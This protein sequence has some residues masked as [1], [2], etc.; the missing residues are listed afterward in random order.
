MGKYYYLNGTE[1]LG[2]FTID[3]LREKCITRETKVW[4]EELG[5]WTPAGNVPQLAQIFGA[6]SSPNTNDNNYRTDGHS[7]SQQP[8]KTWFVES[9]L[10]TVLCCLPFGI[11][12]MISAAKVESLFYSGDMQGAIDES[13]KAKKW[14]N[15]GVWVG[16]SAAVL[17]III[18]VIICVV[19][20]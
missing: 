13:N 12:G 16:V 17:Y 14:V 20:S 11:L 18:I 5:E 2:P 4:T 7:F 6:N 3:E 15:T 8:P 19:N 9:I 10:V 1:S